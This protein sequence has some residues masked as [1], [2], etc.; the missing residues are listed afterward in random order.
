[1]KNYIIPSKVVLKKSEKWV[2][3]KWKPIYQEIVLLSS[4]GK[5]NGEIAKALGFSEQQISNILSSPQAKEEFKRIN[6]KS[7]AKF[8]ED[9]SSRIERLSSRALDNMEK[10]LFEED[11]LEKAPIAM[12]DRSLSFMKSAGKLTGDS[13]KN[14]QTTNIVIG[15]DV[16]SRLLEGLRKSNKVMELHGGFVGAGKLPQLPPAQDSE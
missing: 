12:F 4:G 16:Q 14:I 3:K 15:A 11:Y 1:M 6:E 10:I 5:S 13:P 8:E 9:F 7:R 2:P